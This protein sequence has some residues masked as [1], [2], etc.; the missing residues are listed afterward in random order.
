MTKVVYNACYGGF[1][2]SEA[3]ARRMALL[4]NNEAKDLLSDYEKEGNW[5]GYLYNTPRHDKIL[6][7]AVEEL[8]NAA[9]GECAVLE[10]AE[11]PDGLPYR[12]D[13]YDGMESVETL[14]TYNW[15]IP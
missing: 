9:N 13:E 11:I 6:V 4:E 8:G 1:S 10:I 7:Q 2:I 12:I 14:D 15:I 3:C 5:F